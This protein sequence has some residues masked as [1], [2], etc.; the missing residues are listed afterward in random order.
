MH[1]YKFCK[2]DPSGPLRKKETYIEDCEN[3]SYGVK[4]KIKLSE[5]RFFSPLYNTNIDYMHSILEGV[6]K[7]FFRYWF[8]ENGEQSLK[9]FTQEIDE[10]L[11]SIKPPLFI[12]ITPRSIEQRAKWRANEYLNFLLYYSLPIFCGIMEPKYYLNLMKLVVSMEL[13]LENKIKCENLPIIKNIL[14]S[15]VKEVEDIYPKAIMVS[16]MHEILHLVECTLIFGPLNCTNSFQFEELNRKV[17]SLISGKDL[18]GDEFLKLFLVLQGLTFY[19]FKNDN[20]VLKEYFEKRN[21]IKSSNRKR[22][23]ESKKGVFTPLG[24]ILPASVEISNKI[25]T[26]HSDVLLPLKYCTRIS[27]NGIVYTSLK[28][29]TKRCDYC[30]KTHDESFGLIEFFVYNDVQVYVILKRISKYFHP[31]FDP[32]YPQLKSKS[33]LANFTKSEFISTLDK[34]SKAFLIEINDTRIYISTLSISHLFM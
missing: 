26:Q 22:L 2:D 29:D 21:I 14:I 23:N 1:C 34:I 12:P 24:E 32:L 5:L 18:M 27:F 28:S 8:D 25:M 33:F 7:R 3:Q 16:G 17:I 20:P 30:V 13:L 9:Q 6:V 15:F 10:R 4:G 31:F 11:L 19:S